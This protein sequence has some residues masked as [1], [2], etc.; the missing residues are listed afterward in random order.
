MSINTQTSN[1]IALA[2][3]MHLL[4]PSALLQAHLSQ[5]PQTRPSKRAPRQTRP[6]QLNTSSLTHCNG[7]S[8]VKI[9]ESTV[10]CGIRAEILPVSEI[11]HFRASDQSRAQTGV[12]TRVVSDGIQANGSTPETKEEEEDDDED[13]QS[14]RLNALLVPN[15]ELSTSTHPLFPATTA[16]SITAQSL[17]YRLLSLLHTSRVVRTSDLEIRY[18]PP[19]VSEQGLDPDDP[20]YIEQEA[21]QLKAYWVLYIDCISLG[22]GGE[23]CTF[24]T[25]WCAIYA[26]LKDLILPKAWWDE[27]QR[28]VLC[29]ADMNEARKLNLRGLPV[30]LSFGVFTPDTRLHMSTQV[31]MNG[32]EGQVDTSK[33]IS[34]TSSTLLV[35]LDVFEDGV[36]EEKGSVTLD[37]SNDKPVVIKI[38]KV[39]GRGALEMSDVRTVIQLATARW[40]EFKNVLNKSSIAG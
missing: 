24:D 34:V 25:A 31:Q 40:K 28:I 5:S 20:A 2:S 33:S 4:S 15:L 36:C 22:Y 17:S 14:V 16:P 12:S 26:A 18:T 9:G 10:V 29:S 32:T 3:S 27:D 19:A 21:N 6:I 35:D 1:N 11:P 8:V 7:S 30:P 38:E 13:Y 23:G 37:A 39:G